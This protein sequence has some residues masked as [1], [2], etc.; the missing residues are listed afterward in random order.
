MPWTEFLARPGL[1]AAIGL[2]LALGVAAGAI[3]L[4]RYR[5]RPP[6]VPVATEA[7]RFDVSRS[8]ELVWREVQPMWALLMVMPLAALALLA[9]ALS[10]Q[11]PS[12]VQIVGA[13]LLVPLLLVG[14]LVT[15]VRGNSLCWRFGWLGWPRW[16]LDL[17]D[18][19]AAEPAR[20]GWLEGWGIRF[21]SQGMLYNSHGFEAVSLT[22]RSGRRLRLG[23][24]EPQRL[25]QALAPRIAVPAR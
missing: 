2:G 10:T 5:N 23:S 15:E 24:Q 12:Q 14:R 1:A 11:A 22:L 20:S 13:L 7:R 8:D 17:D 6:A 21:T 25:I 3:V 19:V 9:V 4:I 18:I 16:R